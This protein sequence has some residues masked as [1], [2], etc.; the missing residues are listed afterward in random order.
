MPA[1]LT[2]LL[3][4]RAP[5][6]DSVAHTAELD[7]DTAELLIEYWFLF[8][9]TCDVAM[10]GSGKNRKVAAFRVRGDAA[11]AGAP[12][13]AKRKLRMG[14]NFEAHL[15]PDLDPKSALM[16]HV[17]LSTKDAH[18][19]VLD[20]HVLGRLVEEGYGGGKVMAR[21]AEVV[22]TPLPP[23]VLD[24]VQGRL[25][26]TH[27]LVVG[28]N[29]AFVYCA[30]PGDVTIVKKA[31]GGT[32]AKVIDGRLVLLH[33][34]PTDAQLKTLRAANFALQLED[35]F[36]CLSGMEKEEIEEEEIAEEDDELDDDGMDFARNE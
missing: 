14:A 13:Y 16:A 36:K 35:G 27:E 24:F 28:D 11:A 10:R 22:E 4:L 23:N 5:A 1:D 6:V 29:F 34:E 19:V 26:N 2:E 12:E 33:R 25:A 8:A 15:P 3:A 30:V 17:I 18:T 7:A 31:L 9:L 20:H 32:V 21:I